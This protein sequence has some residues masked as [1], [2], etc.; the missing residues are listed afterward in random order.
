MEKPC[1]R[2]STREWLDLHLP[3]TFEDF[4]DVYRFEP[5]R[6]VLSVQSHLCSFSLLFPRLFLSDFCSCDFVK[7]R[8]ISCR[9]AFAERGKQRAIKIVERQVSGGQNRFNYLL[10]MFLRI[11]T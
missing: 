1:S 8:I 7:F 6:E 3:T 11:A 2:F 4:S 10:S 5:T 9:G